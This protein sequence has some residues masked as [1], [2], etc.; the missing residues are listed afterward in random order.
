MNWS[1]TGLVQIP[2]PQLIGSVKLEKAFYH[3]QTPC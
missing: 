3:S 1:Q 2:T